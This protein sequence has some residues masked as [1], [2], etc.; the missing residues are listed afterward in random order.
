MG[1]RNLRGGEP[2]QS[3]NQ[4]TSRKTRL[5]DK[6][7]MAKEDRDRSKRPLPELPFRGKIVK[8]YLESKG[9]PRQELAVAGH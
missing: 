4:Q 6:E 7:D 1:Y 9:L 8:T 5:K 2:E 3:Y